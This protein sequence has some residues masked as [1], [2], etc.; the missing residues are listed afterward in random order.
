MYSF[1]LSLTRSQ[2]NRKF[3]RILKQITIMGISIML[4]FQR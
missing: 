3:E 1:F 4:K 2:S